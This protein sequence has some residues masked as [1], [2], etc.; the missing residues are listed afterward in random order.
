M[1]KGSFSTCML[2]NE[3]VLAS[4]FS[5]LERQLL[6]G[7]ALPAVGRCCCVLFGLWDCSEASV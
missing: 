5:T 3:P 4:L 7:T 2:V 6:I 1:K